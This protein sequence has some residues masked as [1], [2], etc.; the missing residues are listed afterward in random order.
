MSGDIVSKSSI[1]IDFSG[2]NFKLKRVEKATVKH[3]S[4]T[5]VVLAIGVSGGAGYRDKE[6]GGELTFEFYPET[7]DPEVDYWA[8]FRSR[9][10]FAVVI[11][12]KPTGRRAQYR[13]CRVVSPP[14]ESK[15]ADGTNMNTVGI[16][17]LQWGVL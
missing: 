9:E 3:D 10:Q 14:E 11:Q 5:D 1:S 8:L 12:D 17:F 15:Q 4:T 6:G 2:G 7:G 16:K 13:S